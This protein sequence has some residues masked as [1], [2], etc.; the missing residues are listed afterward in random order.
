MKRRVARER[1]RAEREY[2]QLV[3]ERR[4]VRRVASHLRA[5]PPRFANVLE[6][7]PFWGPAIF[8]GFLVGLGVAELIRSL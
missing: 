2:D 1:S 7:A 4:E 8:I 6:H 3:L 5:R